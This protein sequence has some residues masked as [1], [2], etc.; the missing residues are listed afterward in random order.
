MSHFRFFGK[1][2]LITALFW[3]F[4]D[5]GIWSQEDSGNVPASQDQDIQEGGDPENVNIRYYKIK[6]ELAKHDLQEA[7][8]LNRRIPN[9]IRKV[10][11]LRLQNQVDYA[12]RLLEQAISEEKQDLHEAHLQ[13]L[14]NDRALAERQL[15]WARE[16]NRASSGAIDDDDVTRLQL[17]VQ[18]ARLALERAQDPEV[19]ADP[20]NHL[21]WQID[22]LRSELLRLR[23]EFERTRVGD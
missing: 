15:Q 4:A 13:E 14:K 10:T 9:M 20:V 11:M 1:A 6:L 12:S 23:I 21:Q 19:T 2:F 3:S 18:L 7:V 22:H 17:S 5:P 8:E 16:A